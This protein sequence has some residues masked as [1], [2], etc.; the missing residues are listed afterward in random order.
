MT[1]PE[2]CP[3]CGGA[4]GVVEVRK[5]GQF[6]GRRWRKRRCLKKRCWTEWHTVEVVVCRDEEKPKT[7]EGRG[8]S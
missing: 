7:G 5:N 2:L 8:V 4:S 6:D 1:A 3:K